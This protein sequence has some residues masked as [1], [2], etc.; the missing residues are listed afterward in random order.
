MGHK[1]CLQN[2]I[3]THAHELKQLETLDVEATL[4]IADVEINLDI[5][6]VEVTLEIGPSNVGQL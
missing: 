4:K 5:A 6:D 1:G 3:D 2:H